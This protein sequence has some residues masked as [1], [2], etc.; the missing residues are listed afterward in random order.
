ME[1]VTKTIRL[2]KDVSDRIQYIAKMEDR[3][4]NK[5]LQRLLEKATEQYKLS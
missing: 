1:K 3:S 2:T 5:I 4:F